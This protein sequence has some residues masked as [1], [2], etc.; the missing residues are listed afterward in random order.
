[1]DRAAAGG[2]GHDPALRSGPDNVVYVIYTS[3]ST[4]LPK[5]VMVTHRGVGNL[6]SWMRDAFKFSSSSRVGHTASI[7]F[8]ASVLEIWASLVSGAS[9]HLPYKDAAGSPELL[10]NWLAS[11]QITH[12]FLV[13]ALAEA[14]LPYI[15][16]ASGLSL[17]VLYTGGDKLT[18][19]PQGDVP[20][21][22]YNM[23]GPTEASV[24][25]CCHQVPAGSK[26]IP[27]IGKG[28]DEVRLYLLDEQLQLAPLGLAG[29]LYIG[30]EG[31][32]RGYMG[33]PDLTAEHFIPDPFSTVAGAR[34]YRTGD[35]ARWRDDGVLEYLGRNDFQVKIRGFRIELGE[36]ESKLVQCRGVRE[37]TVIVREDKPGL[38]RLVAYWVPEDMSTAPDVD[39]LRESL[40]QALPSYMMPTSFVKLE[41][42]PV[43]PNGKVDRKALPVPELPANPNRPMDVPK[44]S[45]EDKL[46]KVWLETLQV[47]RVGLDD[48]F[49]DLGGHSMLALQMRSTIQNQ[50]GYDIS[51]VEFFAHPSIRSLAAFLSRDQ[52]NASELISAS[53]RGK[54]ARSYFTQQSRR[55]R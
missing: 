30:G 5:G 1:M 42:L 31:L 51:V 39:S 10:T 53:E 18:R 11:Q 50:L 13:T 28:I 8:D 49:F 4:G 35:L 20:F 23:Y 17:Q 9:L 37:A 6:L 32:A 54:R 33:R 38:K 41:N 2:R 12:C 15:E 19:P 27:P 44:G 29:E 16:Q 55:K 22:F 34:L 46:I 43:N 26:W 25:A 21:L 7:A 36:I 45:I 48:N 24:A 52:G 40:M 14:T 3:G 47:E